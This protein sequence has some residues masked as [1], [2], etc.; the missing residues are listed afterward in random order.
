MDK[1][2]ERRL[3]ASNQRLIN[4][5]TDWVLSQNDIDSLQVISEAIEERKQTLLKEM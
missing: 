1:N 3:E 5:I 2:W 4:L